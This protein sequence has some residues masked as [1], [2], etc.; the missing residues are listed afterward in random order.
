MT[1]PPLIPVDLGRGVRAAFTLGWPEPGSAGEGFN[2]S[3]V[4]GDDVDRVAARLHTLE[5]WVGAPLARARQVHGA[6]VHHCRAAGESVSA[7]ALLSSDPG[8]AVM[9]LVADCVPI[10]LADSAAGVV[11]SV[12]AG[13]RGMVGGVVAAAV[14][15]MSARG[16][17][18]G[19]IRAV[20][21]PAICGSCY[22][23]PSELRDEVEAAVP[24]TAS[25][26]SWATPALDLHSGIAA[27]L[28]AAGV[29]TVERL[30][31][32]TLEDA[33][34]FSHRAVAHGRPPG[35]F[36]GLVRLLG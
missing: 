2:L 35:R 17:S 8:L 30:N 15:A 24:G 34:F 19:A 3:T 7:D 14:A 28:D 11:A 31:I 36:A 20:V 16:A 21:G 4:L 26:T 6:A 33:R 12:H 29:R 13:R 25:T 23:V 18:V 5:D 27:Q 22:E 9:V 1:S 32:C 10:L